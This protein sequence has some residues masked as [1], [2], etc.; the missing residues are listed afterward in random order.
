LRE[1]GLHL[2]LVE[3]VGNA[4]KHMLDIGITKG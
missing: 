4:S 2:V 1:V 3:T